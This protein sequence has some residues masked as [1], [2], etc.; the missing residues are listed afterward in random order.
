MPNNS[1]NPA[2]EPTAE[3]TIEPNRESPI[4][5]VLR[6]LGSVLGPVIGLALVIGIFGAWKPDTFLS[7][8]AFQSV[9]ENNYHYV[10]AAIGATFVI[11]TAGIDLSVGSTMGLASVC[12]AM[13]AAGMQFPDFEWQQSLVIGGGMALLTGLCVGGW[14]LQRGWAR[15][16][17]FCWALGSAAG[18]AAVS[19]L[20]W[21]LLGGATIAPMPVGVALLVGV[22]SGALVGLLNGTLISTLSL[23]P[24]IVTLATLGAVRGLTLYI[25]GGIPVPHV[26]ESISTLCTTEIPGCFQALAQSLDHDRRRGDF[27]PAVAFHDFRPLCIRD[28]LERA[29]G[30]AVRRPRRALENAVLRVRGCRQYRAWP[31]AG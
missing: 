24:F 2:P 16:R 8:K 3:A 22:G 29:H 14:T 15:L 6:S 13:A 27:D 30:P 5:G 10:I 7:G 19:M 23:P 9:F 17:A 20:V 28:R 4:V 26:P 1:T 12:C 25:T 18:A 11:I 21:R 31:G